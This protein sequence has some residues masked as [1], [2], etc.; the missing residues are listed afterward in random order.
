MAVEIKGGNGTELVS[1]DPV[2]KAIRVI[3]YASDGHEGIHSFPEAVTTNNATALNEFVLPA[4]LA[5]DYKFI[6][7]QLVGSWVA[8]V[9]FEGS[10]D[11]TTFYAIATTD[12]SSVETGSS[13]A[14]TN[15]L[16][17][18]PILFQY[19][20]ARVS[21]YTS[22]TISASAFGHRDENSSG[23][24][25]TIGEV[26]LAPETTKKIGNVGLLSDGTPS[27]QKFISAAGLNATAVKG[28]PAKLTILNIVNGAATL[29][30]F[31]IYNKAS[32]PTVGTDIPLITI[33]LPNGS[34]SFTLPAFIGIDFSVGL[35]FACT[36]GVADDDTTPFTVV[37]EVTAMLAYI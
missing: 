21:A 14:T 35:S 16:V 29:R 23:L 7:V 11:N 33:T 2:S 8:T 12:P 6:S 26:V 13:T 10:N 19:V 24:V 25:S 22:G 30:Y 5:Q 36:L 3:N 37:G 18:I 20:R 31:K 28:S 1:V 27:Y 9:T 17:K 4:I 32:A 34:S 15:R